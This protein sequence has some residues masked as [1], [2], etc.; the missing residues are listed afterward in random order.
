MELLYLEIVQLIIL[1]L[2]VFALYDQIIKGFRKRFKTLQRLVTVLI[3]NLLRIVPRSKKIII[4]GSE[5]G[6]AFRG[7][8]KYLFYELRKIEGMRCI[9]IFKNNQ[10]VQDVR[11]QGYEGYHYMSWKGIYFQLRAKNILHSHS[12]NDDFNKVLLGGA[13]SVNTWHGV[14]LKKVWG[15]NSKTYS[16][17]ALHE[18]NKIKRFFKMLM[19]RTSHAKVNYIISTSPTVSSYYPETF[20]VKPENVLEVGQ[21]RN[22]VFF[23]D[24]Y[25]ESNIPEYFKREKIILYMPTFR[26]SKEGTTN[27]DEIF[28][29]EH[30]N[31]ICGRYGYK[32]VIKKHMYDESVGNI[33][34]LDHIVDISKCNYDSQLLL[35]YADVLITDYSS[36]Y[37]DYLLLNRPVLFYCYDYETYLASE[38]EMYFNYDE[39]TP[40]PKAKSL[41]E[42]LCELEKTLSGNDGYQSER[43]RVLN[44]FYSKANQKPVVEKQVKKILEVF[45][46]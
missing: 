34:G 24:F 1:V 36:C 5:N 13:I 40:G 46:L 35:K 44:I 18:K 11:R 21:A 19:A 41:E 23:R 22:D 17:K 42:L 27:T 31:G 16:Y 26:K 38:R 3:Y 4:F 7:N 28:N 8:P 9:W 39:V 37:T 43:E 20:L 32:F 45:S 12:I 15:A 6:N 2:L 25:D 30:I 33:T 29:L 14:G 10:A